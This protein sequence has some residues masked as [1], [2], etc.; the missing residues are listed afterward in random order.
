MADAVHGR[1]GR[2]GPRHLGD[3]KSGVHSRLALLLVG[4]VLVLVGC[5]NGPTT[6]S[7]PAGTADALAFTGTTLGGAELDAATLSGQP[8]ALWFWA[9]WCTIC[10]AEAP[11]VAS[12]A[13]QFEDQ[14]TFIG[15][16]GLGPVDDMK[17]FVDETGTEGFEHVIDADGSLWQRFGVV[18]QPSFVFVATDGTTQSFT[19]ALPVDE[20]RRMASALAAG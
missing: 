13:A 4:A 20:L 9:P 19:G 11:E 12:V 3:R 10:R 5:A 14:V 6:Q 15:I 18:S 17:R 7:T 16:P 8:V 1:G 2:A